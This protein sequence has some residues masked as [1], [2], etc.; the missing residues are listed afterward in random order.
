MFQTGALFD[1]DGV[2]IDSESR[3]TEFWAGIERIYPTGIPNY[4]VAIKG[5]TLGE[6]LKNYDSQEVRDDIVARLE[7][8]QDNMPFDIYPGAVEFIESLDRAGIPVAMVTSSDHRKMGL[9]FG[10]HPRLKPLFKV[11]VDGSMVSRSK[12][13][14]EGYRKAAALIGVPSER[15][16][17][18]EDSIQGLLA[19][20]AAGGRVVGVATTWPEERIAPMA[21]LVVPTLASMSLD[22]FLTLMSD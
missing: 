4:P 18:F 3:Y 21:D 20:R 14:P 9:L 16:C 10:A 13:D 12:P 1:L 11:I 2:I 17:V 5:T 8:F 6:I 22:R 7:H 19:G 15:C